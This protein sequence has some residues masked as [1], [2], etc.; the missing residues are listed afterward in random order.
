[1]PGARFHGAPVDDSG[2]DITRVAPDV[3]ARCKLAYLT[4]S[5]QYPTGAVM[6]LARR[7]EVL[8][9]AD[10]HDAYVIED[11]YDSEFRYSG[12]A[13]EAMKSL[14]GSGR[15]IYVGTFSKTLFPSLRIAYVALPDALVEPFRSAKWLSDWASPRFEQ[16]ALA[17]FLASGDFER[18][19]RRARTLYGRSREALLAAIGEHLR[20]LGAEYRDSQ[21]GLHLRVRLPGLQ[22]RDFD[23]VDRRAREADVAVYSTQGCYLEEP[24]CARTRARVHAP[25]RRRHARR[26]RT[27]RRSAK[28]LRTEVR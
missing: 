9:W 5:H 6:S 8:R 26:H 24:G 16:E 4:P 2:A 18:H 10:A 19:T 25:R 7:L 20:P 17:D 12:R 11:D 28:D 15:V 1:M 27:A 22:R 13:I 23:E 14:D 3:L 21:A